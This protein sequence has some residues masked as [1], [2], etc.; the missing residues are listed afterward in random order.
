[1]S[2]Q[3][4]PKQHLELAS[5]KLLPH[6]DAVMQFQGYKAPNFTS[7]YELLY[8]S[9]NRHQ[10]VKVLKISAVERQRALKRDDDL[11]VLSL[12]HSLA[13]TYK[14]LGQGQEA[15]EE[16]VVVEK[17]SAILDEDRPHTLTA[18][19]NLAAIYKQLGQIKRAKELE[20]IVMEKR[21]AILGEDHPQTL[22]AMH[23]LAATYK[24]L[25][26]AKKA[27]ELEVLLVEK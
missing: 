12:M 2:I 16:V 27:E 6:L 19:C 24:Q 21:R 15:Q 9:A 22:T 14:D 13:A 17:Q 3:G 25:G 26:Q 4:I 23:N 7:N 8:A 11:D 1:M 5:L 10:E 20:V 18:M